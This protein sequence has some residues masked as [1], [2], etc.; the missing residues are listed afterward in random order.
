M[1]KI[2]KYCL[3]LVL[4]KSCAVSVY[5]Q[6]PEIKTDL[7][8]SG[9]GKVALK[10]AQRMVA[11]IKLDWQSAKKNVNCYRFTIKQRIR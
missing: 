1:Q 8:L 10:W 7:K 9:D 6:N 4:S 3:T 5:S 2:L 11:L